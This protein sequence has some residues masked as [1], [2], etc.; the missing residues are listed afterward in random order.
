MGRKELEPVLAISTI[1]AEAKDVKRMGEL[2]VGVEGYLSQRKVEMGRE[3]EE[4]AESK[5]QA[6]VALR[7][8]IVITYHARLTL[9]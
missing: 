7:L 5:G 1:P 2:I 6:T 9:L 4:L 3:D 8:R